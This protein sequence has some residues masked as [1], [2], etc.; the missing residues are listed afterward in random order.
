MVKNCSL[1]AVPFI[2]LLTLSACTPIARGAQADYPIEAPDS[3]SPVTVLPGQSLYV[4]VPYARSSIENDQEYD[5]YF[6]AIEFDYSAVRISTDKVP[7]AY[8]DAPWLTLKSVDAPAGITVALVKA[9]IGRVVSQTK[10]NGTSVNVKYG[11][12]FRLQYKISVAADFKAPVTNTSDTEALS[13]TAVEA[14]SSL[15]PE[16]KAVIGAYGADVTRAKL[17]FADATGT[18]S[19]ILRISTT[20]RK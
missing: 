3:F 16:L 15:S 1:V 12:R 14:M 17:T 11:E 18:K 9:N 13:P 7:D 20:A 2:A 19:A 4:T 6:D 10:V 8:R 5:A